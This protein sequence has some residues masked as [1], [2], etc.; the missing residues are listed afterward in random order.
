MAANRIAKWNGTQWSALGP[1]GSGM[2]DGVHALT[3]FNELTG[4]VLYVG[5]GF[6]TA[7][8]RPSSRIAAWRCAPPPP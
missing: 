2:N 3:V 7:A 6:T 5:G 8:N 1:M 4:P